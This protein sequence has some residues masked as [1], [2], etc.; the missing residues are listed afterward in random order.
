M[1]KWRDAFLAEVADD[2]AFCPSA[3]RAVSADRSGARPEN[4]PFGTIGTNGTGAEKEEAPRQPHLL[5]LTALTARGYGAGS[6]RTEH[7]RRLSL[8]RRGRMTP[9]EAARRAYGHAQLDWHQ[10]H[11]ERPD[12]TVCPGCGMAVGTAD[13]LPLAGG[14]VHNL[15]CLR[16]YGLRWRG[17]A[18]AGLRGLGIEPPEGWSNEE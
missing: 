4:R 8:Y 6:P 2:P 1:G 16:A 10:R 3:N 13:V 5:A 17:A 18:E 9:E 12:P 15:D 14:A 11:G 7:D